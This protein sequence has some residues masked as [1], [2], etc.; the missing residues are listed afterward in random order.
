MGNS[1][2]WSFLDFSVTRLSVAEF[3][4]IYKIKER[5][6]YIEYTR[7][8]ILGGGKLDVVRGK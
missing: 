5:L 2:L 7:R 8:C 4:E 3:P 6:N 1:I